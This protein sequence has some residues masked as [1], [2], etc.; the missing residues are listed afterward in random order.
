MGLGQ[1]ILAPVG[2]VVLGH[3]RDN[4]RGRV[5]EDRLGEVC[6]PQ[7]WQLVSAREA[8]DPGKP[9][10]LRHMRSRALSPRVGELREARVGLVWPRGDRGHLPETHLFDDGRPAPA[11][12]DEARGELLAVFCDLF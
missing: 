3:G 4:R 6:A 10:I 8:P 7:Q 12:R 5:A 9:I 2:G 1:K 11:R